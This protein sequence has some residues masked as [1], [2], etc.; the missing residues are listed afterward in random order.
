MPTARGEFGVAVVNGKIFAIGGIN[1]DGLPLNTNEEY[2]PQTDTWES[3]TPMPTSRSG[4]AI[5]VYFGKIYVIGGTVGNGFVGNNE[6][7]DPISNTWEPKASMPTPR[8]DLSASVI[9]DKIYL[10][11]GRKYSSTDP[12]FNETSV[13]EVYDPIKDSWSSS[14]PIPTAVSGYSS[15]V[16][17]DKI[18]VMGGALRSIAFGNGPATA[19]NQVFDAQTGN[20]T[21]STKLPNVDCYGA[22]VATEGYMAP[23]EIYSV[24]GYFGGILSGQTHAYNLEN[25]T[26]TAGDSMPTA[27]AYFS[28]AIVGD[29]LYAIGGFDGTNWLNVNEQYK[30]IGYGT[31]APKVQITSPENKTYANVTLAFTVNRGIQWMGYSLDN[32]SN[33]TINAETALSR[34]SQGSHNVTIYAND[35]SGNMGSSNIVFFSI[36]TLPPII[37]ILIPQNQSY[38]STDIQLT[39][40]VNENVSYLAY[41]LDGQ[42][43]QEIAGNVTL[44]ALTSGP[45]TLTLYASDELGNAGQKSVSFNISPFP[46]VEIVAVITIVTIA[47]ASGYLLFKRKKPGDN[48]EQR[49]TQS[50]N[51]NSL[52]PKESDIKSL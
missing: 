8:A 49:K 24:G 15:V 45:H 41:D 48:K 2:N 12:Y 40:N 52:N 42:E 35:T 34:L 28:V 4:F 51:P 9:N 46:M 11:G 18:Y 27:R 1:G 43:K 39:F 23:T 38:D 37:D 10:I 19:S 3:M 21:L 50:D 7:Y 17:D 29:V 14:K 25:N 20:W 30:P 36:D 47:L 44:A 5:V 32:H 13:N 16:L 33:I 31:V 26:W 6:V 22:A